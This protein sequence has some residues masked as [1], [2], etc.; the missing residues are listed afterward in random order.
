MGKTIFIDGNPAEGIEGSIVLAEFLNAI[1]NHRHTGQ[2]VDGAGAID[3]ANDAG[4]ANAYEISLV[5]A[6][7]SNIPG[8][9]I[10]FKAA[11]ANTGASTLDVNGIGAVAIKKYVGSALTE[12][13]IA[14]GQ[15]VEVVYDGTNF[16][17]VN[18][19]AV[20]TAGAVSFRNLK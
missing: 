9:P 6:I 4:E 8:M 7:T 19:S 16:Q 2:D 3:Y 20:N 11:N 1:N 17:I 18:S 14:A 10:F 12:G 15:I 5:P 13:D